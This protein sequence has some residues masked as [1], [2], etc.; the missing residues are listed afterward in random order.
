MAARRQ[1]TEYCIGD[2]IYHSR[3]LLEGTSVAREGRGQGREVQK[4]FSKQ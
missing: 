4:G 2:N 3:Y 1:A